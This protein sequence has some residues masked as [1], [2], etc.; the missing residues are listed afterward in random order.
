[1]CDGF[2]SRWGVTILAQCSEIWRHLSKGRHICLYQLVVN[3]HEIFKQI[4][5]GDIVGSVPD[6]HD[7]EN[8][9]IK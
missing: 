1:M 2:E 8:I 4:Y 7:K 9:T 3:D 5:L 6:Q